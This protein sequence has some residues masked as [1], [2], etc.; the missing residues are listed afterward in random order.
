MNNLL[1]II[2]PVHTLGTLMLAQDICS[3]TSLKVGATRTLMMSYS[4]QMAVSPICSYVY[5]ATGSIS[6][7]LRPWCFFCNGTLHG[8]WS[9]VC[10]QSQN[11]LLIVT[12]GPCTISGPNSTEYNPYS[13]NSNA[14]IFFVDQPVGTGFS[15]ADFNETVVSHYMITTHESQPHNSIAHYGGGSQRYRKLCRPLLWNFW[16]IQGSS[17]PSDGGVF[18][19]N[20]LVFRSD[21]PLI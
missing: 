5:G 3:S 4:G 21:S 15:Y 17:F 8:T 13:W 20:V 12:I 9:V 2:F 6:V 10:H 11:I 1:H 16:Q 19:R 7:C 18:R 14:N